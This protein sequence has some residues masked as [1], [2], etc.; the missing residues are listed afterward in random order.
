MATAVSAIGILSDATSVE[1]II[2][3]EV[4]V[5]IAA[6]GEI[7]AAIQRVAKTLEDYMI[8]V[9]FGDQ[10]EWRQLANGAA[11]LPHNQWPVLHPDAVAGLVTPGQ[12]QVA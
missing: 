6:V 11:G 8:G 7:L 4:P 3:F 2:S 5:V 12:W 1:S 10:L 9:G